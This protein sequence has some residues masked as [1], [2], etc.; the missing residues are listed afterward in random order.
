MPSESYNLY[1]SDFETASGMEPPTEDQDMQLEQMPHETGESGQIGNIQSISQRPGCPDF[2]YPQGQF[3]IA[4][5]QQVLNFNLDSF[6]FPAG[7][8][9]FFVA[10]CH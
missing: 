2:V 4:P 6:N 7:M 8:H 10:F 9:N 5:P 3:N 1:Q